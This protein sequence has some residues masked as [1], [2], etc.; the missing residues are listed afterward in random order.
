MVKLD[1]LRSLEAEEVVRRPQITDPYPYYLIIHE[2]TASGNVN[3]IVRAI[4]LLYER[5]WR[6]AQVAEHFGAGLSKNS[7]VFYVTMER[8]PKPTTPPPPPTQSK[9]EP[10][11]KMPRALRKLSNQES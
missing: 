10:K 3:F 7:V 11:I 8:A 5:G 2:T 9:P 6:V 1:D 4:N